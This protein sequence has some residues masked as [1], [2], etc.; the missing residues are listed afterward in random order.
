MS[1]LFNIFFDQISHLFQ[2]RPEIQAEKEFCQN[3]NLKKNRRKTIKLPTDDAAVKRN[4]KSHD[5]N[6][7]TATSS[8]IH[9][10]IFQFHDVI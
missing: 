8:S 6:T 7:G 2:Q 3:E 4:I 1:I 5:V 9:V 10:F